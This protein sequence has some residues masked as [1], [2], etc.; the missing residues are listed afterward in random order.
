MET[1]YHEIK[2][3]LYLPNH[4]QILNVFAKEICLLYLFILKLLENDMYIY[5]DAGK[6]VFLSSVP[7]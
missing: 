1:H 4:T 7:S 3:K 2:G 6:Y 5:L